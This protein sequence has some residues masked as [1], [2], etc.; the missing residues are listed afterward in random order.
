[1]LLCS[2]LFH[3]NILNRNSKRIPH[4]LLDQSGNPGSLGLGGFSIPFM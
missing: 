2:F 3:I 1:M 4:G